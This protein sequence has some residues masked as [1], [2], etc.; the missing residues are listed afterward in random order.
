MRRTPPHLT[1]HDDLPRDDSLGELSSSRRSFARVIRLLGHYI[2]HPQARMFRPRIALAFLF[3]TASKGLAVMVPFCFKYVVDR[4]NA[5]TLPEL[6]MFSLV[7]YGGCRMG[8]QICAELKDMAFARLT[9]RTA[10]IM[11]LEVFRH[12]H[13]LS[14]RF[15][16]ERKTGALTRVLER[17]KTGVENV[18]HYLVFNGLPTVLEMLLVLVMVTVLYDGWITGIIGGTLGCYV[19]WTC[20]LSEWRTSFVRRMNNRDNRIHTQAIDSLINYETVKI[21]GIED[22]ESH[23]FEKALGDY[24][25][26][27]VQSRISLAWL[28]M[29]Q[30]VIISSGLVI[31]LVV[32]F[33]RFQNHTLTAGDFV[34]LNQCM[35]QLYV[36]L[37]LLGMVYREVKMGLINIDDM[38]RLLRETP[39]V[40]VQ[41]GAPPLIRGSG[42]VVFDRV[43]FGY[44]DQP[45]LLQDVSF[46]IPPGGTLGVVGPSGAGKSTLLRLFFRFYDVTSGAITVDGQDIRSLDPQSLRSAIGMVPQ[47]SVLF[48][49]TVRYNIACGYPEATDEEVTEAARQARIHSTIKRWPK[50]YNTLVGE[51]GLKLS[52]GEKQ[53]VAIAR[54]L[55]KKPLIL[56][57]DEATSALDSATERDIQHHL[58]EIAEHHTTLI[59]AHRLSTVVEADHILVLSGGGIAEQ[60]THTEL[61]AWQGLYAHMWH[62]QMSGADP[63]PLA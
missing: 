3:L 23:R 42:E 27:A 20:I 38:M 24:E 41:P 31:L 58:N 62:L 52:G 48:N 61:L 37:N 10:R 44:P 60:G 49:D 9:Q 14:L 47:D 1:W 51:R 32:A 5:R 57:F 28:N 7:L 55:L 43:S 35:L 59:V 30:S 17:G 63:F 53:R 46:R 12:L 22:H 18:L 34:L 50:E 40:P 15:H 45:P 8:A 25:Q 36:P 54:C 33:R 16:L 21:F 29:G 11:S 19:A 26:A 2:W 56:V 4:L 39:D 6:V 13:R